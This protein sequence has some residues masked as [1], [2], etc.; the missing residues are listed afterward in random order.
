MG[1][2]CGTNFRILYIKTEPQDREELIELLAPSG[3]LESPAERLLEIIEARCE[4]VVIERNYIDSDYRAGFARFHYLR[5]HDTPRRCVRLHFFPSR[6]SPSNLADIPKNMKQEYLGFTVLRPLPGFH[7][8]RSLLSVG[9][10]SQSQPGES[11]YITCNSPCR[12]NL[13]GNEIEFD[14][15]PWMQQD[16]LVSACASAAIWVASCYLARKFPLEFREYSTPEITDLATRNVIST[17]RPMPSEGLFPDQMM[18]ALQEMGYEPVPYVPDTAVDATRITYRY[19]ESGIPVIAGVY[20]PRGGGHAVT[21]IGHTH[22]MQQ[23]PQV[24]RVKL[25]GGHLSLCRSSDFASSFVI[26]DDAGGP[27]RR[28]E[29]IDWKDAVSTNWVSKKQS[30]TLKSRYGCLVVLDKGTKSEEVGFLQTLLTPLPG[31]VT[32]N[33]H[34]AEERSI[35]LVV[36]W[37]SSLGLVPAK[38]VVLRTFLEPSNALKVRFGSQSDISPVLSRELRR[39]IMSKWV[40]V[41]EVADLTE[42]HS[43]KVGYGIVFQDCASHAT[44]P[45]FFDL[46]AFHLP[47]VLALIPPDNTKIK[48]FGIPEDERFPMLVRAAVSP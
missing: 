35:E 23:K 11:T 46:V 12:A 2:N 9:M 31:G 5:H 40:W 20:F 27:F 42:F 4:T 14:G 32:L 30:Q 36:N 13:A 16:T 22:N 28:L 3:E 33:G 15:V 41:T 34:G 6:L 44:S 18:Y 1:L 24:E 26:Q 39:H 48:T 29:F 43:M 47:G 19:V 45:D 17:G 7:L 8:G 25:N 10:V 37:Y 38:T 21:A